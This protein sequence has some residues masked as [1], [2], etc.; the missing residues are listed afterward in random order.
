ML[1]R[2][3]AKLQI[4]D[5]IAK[6]KCD[7]ASNRRSTRVAVV[8][9][10]RMKLVSGK[11]QQIA[12]RRMNGPG[13]AVPP[14]ESFNGRFRRIVPVEME[15]RSEQLV[16]QASACVKLNRGTI[17]R[18]VDVVNPRNIAARMVVRHHRFGFAIRFGVAQNKPAF[19]TL[20]IENVCTHSHFLEV[21]TD[22]LGQTLKKRAK[23]W[24]LVA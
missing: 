16:G 14:I 21:P 24:F 6:G 9:F 19:Q 18:H 22:V 1:R 23:C 2:S 7:V 11:K 12:L 15:R 4:V 17:F 13:F 20:C 3:P 5:A 8:C 10:D